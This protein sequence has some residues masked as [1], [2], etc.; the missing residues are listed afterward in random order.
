MNSSYCIS[1]LF[2]IHM[3]D[4]RSEF[5]YFI[6]CDLMTNKL[7]LNSI[8]LYNSPY[9]IDVKDN[10]EWVEYCYDITMNDDI[11][12]IKIL[13][14]INK[15]LTIKNQSIL[16]ID[17]I[18]TIIQQFFK[19]TYNNIDITFIPS[20]WNKATNIIRLK[21]NIYKFVNIM[22]PPF[23][24]KKKD[25]YLQF[26][27]TEE[28]IRN[29]LK[30]MINNIPPMEQIEMDLTNMIEKCIKKKSTSFT[31]NVIKCMK[32][33]D[34]NSCKKI[35][36]M[37]DYKDIIKKE[38][39]EMDVCSAVNLLVQF[40]F[41]MKK[42]TTFDKNESKA[43]F[44]SLFNYQ[45][46]ESYEMWEKRYKLLLEL[47]SINDKF[48]YYIKLLLEKA[49]PINELRNKMETS[50]IGMIGGGIKNVMNKYMGKNDLLN[51]IIVKHNIMEEKYHT[52]RYI[53]INYG[54]FIKIFNN[55]KIF[56]YNNMALYKRYYDKIYYKYMI[57]Q[58][59]LL[60]MIDS[61]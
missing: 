2:S 32:G 54:Q 35:M 13:E 14:N 53:V 38:I 20:Q 21:Y 16:F 55:K 1:K 50:N 48:S 25:E 15:Q 46:F 22:A 31:D 49:N 52:A 12:D 3:N 43:S 39:N 30:S 4:L 47:P 56:N 29:M 5:I 59:E 45:K 34:I 42:N 23:Y 61:N 28:I 51:N 41:K 10:I 44:S 26:I 40:G 36:S 33:K 19:I 60:D 27:F 58:K 8:N 57:I 17:R 9:M 6:I 18:T 7:E 24:S 11:I 37:E